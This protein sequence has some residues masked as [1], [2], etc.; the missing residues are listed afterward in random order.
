MTVSSGSK[1][2]MAATLKISMGLSKEIP[3]ISSSLRRFCIIRLI[4]AMSIKASKN[5]HTK[6]DNPRATSED[7]TI[8]EIKKAIPKKAELSENKS[9]E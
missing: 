9:P 2:L 5:I 8:E 6:N 3:M 1:R 4:R 7:L